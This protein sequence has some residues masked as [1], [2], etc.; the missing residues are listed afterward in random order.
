[1]VLEQVQEQAVA[2]KLLYPS[3]R[4]WSRPATELGGFRVMINTKFTYAEGSGD[5][6]TDNDYR[7]IGL[8]INP[9][10]YGT[11]ELTS[12]LTLSATKAVI[13]S[14]TFTGNFQTDEI[15]TQSRLL[16]VNR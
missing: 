2:S 8:V 3:K 9:N 14:P 4:T 5:F 16:V 12:D 15:I 1:M 10:K 7:R 13:F 11:E 6:P